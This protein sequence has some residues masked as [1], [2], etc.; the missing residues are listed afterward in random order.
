MEA[1]QTDLTGGCT[2]RVAWMLQ[3]TKASTS[4]SLCAFLPI[5]LDP[6]VRENGRASE[7]RRGVVQFTE[8]NDVPS[9]TVLMSV[10][11]LVQPSLF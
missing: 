10:E 5:E 2:S 6:G 8:C 1:R 7:E 9:S 4:T 11:C 3:Q